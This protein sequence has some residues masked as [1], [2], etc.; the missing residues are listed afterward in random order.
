[1]QTPYSL[2]VEPEDDCNETQCHLVIPV[3]SLNSDYCISAEGVSKD[4][5]VKTETSDELCITTSDNN[6]MEGKFLLFFPKYR[7]G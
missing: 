5:L 6:R 3:S 7:E 2:Q 1:M 4:W